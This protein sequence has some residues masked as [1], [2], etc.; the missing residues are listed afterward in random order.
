MRDTTSSSRPTA[1]PGWQ[2][3]LAHAITTLD[4]LAAALELPAAS[5]GKGAAAAA[6]F[7]LRVPRSFVARMRKG[8]PHDPLL[9]QVLPLARELLPV[10]GYGSDPLD[11]VA[12]LQQPGLLQKYRGRALLVTTGACA[13]NCRYCFRR[14]F[15]YA[16]ASLTP[17]ALDGVLQALA[18]DTSI[19][20]LI[21]SGGDPLS[22]ADRRLAGLIRAVEDMHHVRRIRIHTRLPIVLPSRVDAGLLGVL[23][24]T[25]RQL[26]VVLHAN[27]PQELDAEVAGA[28][29]RLRGACSLLLN[30]SVLL[31]GVNDEP[32]TLVALSQRLFDIGVLPYYLHLLDPVRGA[33]HFHVGERRAR[34]IMGEVAAA[35]PGYLVPRLARERPG[36]PAKEVLAPMLH[37]PAHAT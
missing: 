37:K 33:A 34:R 10:R 7:A 4:E 18:D 13:V 22:L 21:L 3:E 8:D 24:Q 31:R 16:S 36:A 19:E 5:L 14:D 6:D 25:T 17:R 32:A 30:Q 1:A 12:G 23:A 20:E 15:P 27:H 35:L 26:V 29:A 11:E 28:A 9:L 2:H